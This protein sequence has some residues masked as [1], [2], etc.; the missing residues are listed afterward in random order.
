MNRDVCSV[1]GHVEDRAAHSVQ[2]L[3]SSFA[4]LINYA[5]LHLPNFPRSVDVGQVSQKLPTHFLFFDVLA[6]VLHCLFV[7]ARSFDKGG[8]AELGSKLRLYPGQ[9]AADVTD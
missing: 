3:K 1:G 9:E 4:V 5:H 7:V 6:E 2:S 8:V